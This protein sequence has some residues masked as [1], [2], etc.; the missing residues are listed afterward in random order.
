MPDVGF[1]NLLLVLAIAF[2]VPL[3]LGL[4]PKVRIPSVAVEILA[5][6]VLGPAVLGWIDVD[7]PVSILALL[8]LAVLL[9]LSGLEID[10]RRLRGAT[11]RRAAA[12]FVLTLALGLAVGVGAGA[13]GLTRS[14]LLLAVLLSATSLGVVVAVL[15]D[16]GE[17]GSA[18]GQLILAGSSIADLGA[19]VLLSLLFSSED[20]TAGT[21]AILLGGFVLVVGVVALVVAGAERSMRLSATLVRLQDTTAQIRVRG[22]LVLL[23]AFASFAERF[24]LEAIL[25]AFI[26]GMLLGALDGDP[27]RTHPQ[28][29]VKLEAIGFGF[30]IPVYFVT[31]GLRFDLDA[32]TAGPGVVARVPLYLAALL[33][34]R[35]VP[36][37]LYRGEI[38]TRRAVAAGLLQ[39]TSLPFLVAGS[40]IGQALGLLSA[41]NAAALVAAGLVSVLV[42][43]VLASR[44]LGPT[45]ETETEEERSAEAPT[46]A[47]GGAASG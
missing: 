12:G 36:A 16:A 40:Q 2:C 37:L 10:L 17:A 34:V 23:V 29:G 42:F 45:V 25:G 1:D 5:G 9:L 39:A 26:A 11:G 4:L 27:L 46:A 33:V 28:L 18:T 32:L 41:A 43:P 30:L 44:L 13:A 35:G 14:P 22:A 7:L 6:I 19:I 47:G 20:T 3:G 21:R 38:G 31:S 24:G 8:G 15:K